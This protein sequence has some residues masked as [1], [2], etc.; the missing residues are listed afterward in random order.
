MEQKFKN[1]IRACIAGLV[2]CSLVIVLLAFGLAVSNT[3]NTKLNT[4]SV[5]AKVYS[6]VIVA[7]LPKSIT[8]NDNGKDVT[9][10]MDLNKDF[11]AEKDEPIEQYVPYY[12]DDEGKRIDLPT[13]IYTSP[14]TGE[15]MQVTVGFFLK[16][17]NKLKVA[18][19]TLKV[20]MTIF[21]LGLIATIILLSY[22]IWSYRQDQKDALQ[23]DEIKKRFEKKDKE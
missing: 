23:Y 13:G 5:Q 21:V 18:A 12:M 17:S 11:D 15:K 8:G 3:S 6:K 1:K 9:F 20:F 16:G 14:T 22:L 4:N 10:Y 7:L 19:A 2:A